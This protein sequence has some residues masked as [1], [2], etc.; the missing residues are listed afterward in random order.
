MSRLGQTKKIFKSAQ[1]EIK[2][3]LHRKRWRE[4]L[5][6]SAFV[7]LS[8]GFWL[9]QSLQ[10]EYEITLA[11]PVKYKN[12]P[13]DIAFTSTKP[14]EITAKVKD[15][16][17]VLLNYTFGR[18]FA[19]IEVNMKNQSDEGK[20]LVKK[21]EIESNIQKQLISTTSLVGFEPQQ[22]DIPYNKRV[23]KDI[24]VGFNGVVQTE[25]GFKVSGSIL[26]S[27]SDIHVYATKAVLDTIDHI[28]TAFTEIKK[29]NKT[30]TRNVQLLPIEGT[31]FEPATVTLT[32]P[33][34]EFTEKTLEIPIICN[35]LP[36]YYTLRM[37]PSVI[38]VTCSLPLS[39]FKEI[40][41]EDFAILISFSNLEQNVSGSLPIQ[42]T[43]K[44]NWVENVTLVPDQI[45]F[46]LEQ[47]RT[48]D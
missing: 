24:P 47:N 29:G 8:F 4:A 25:P 1:K 36:P 40:S 43:K 26:I 20:L 39:R 21:K 6:F 5:I 35:N 18:T 23:K 41:E 44:P 7:L 37:F 45:E 12:I 16:G 32:I 46:I 17:S 48:N 28:K 27:P 31:T 10:Q 30:I 22:I 3:S 19:P 42:L 38:K 33:V 15:K 2:A 13:P 9:L 14:T 11:I 34:E